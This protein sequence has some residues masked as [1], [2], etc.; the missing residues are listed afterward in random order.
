MIIISHSM[1]DIARYADLILVLKQ[2]RVYT[3]GTVDEI[4]TNANK[5]FDAS[6]DLPQITK[7]FIELEKRRICSETNCFTVEKAAQRILAKC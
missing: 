7:L 2:G 4:F 6:L 1:E 3:Y 5:L